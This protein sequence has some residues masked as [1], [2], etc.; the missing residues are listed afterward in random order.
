[1]QCVNTRRSGVVVV[2]QSEG[3]DR[4]LKVWFCCLCST[5]SR[6]KL[7]RAGGS[8]SDGGS[9]SE[10]GSVKC[11]SFSRGGGVKGGSVSKGGSVTKKAA[12][13]KEVKE[14]ASLRM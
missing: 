3:P 12:S 14:A 2:G 7:S 13:P 9:V 5:A 8:V 1:M 6:R 10:D 4:Q 11:S